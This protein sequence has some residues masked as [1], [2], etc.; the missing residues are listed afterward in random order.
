M[1]GYILVVWSELLDQLLLVNQYVDDLLDVPLLLVKQ[2]V[3]KL[4]LSK[5]HLEQRV[6]RLHIS[7]GLK[8]QLVHLLIVQL[9]D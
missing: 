1:S 3:V 4:E 8:V 9:V 7:V 2:D 5:A 6:K